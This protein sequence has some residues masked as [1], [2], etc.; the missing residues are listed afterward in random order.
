MISWI[1]LYHWEDLLFA[2]FVGTVPAEIEDDTQV[3]EVRSSTGETV[4]LPCVVTG[5][6]Q[7][8]IH[9]TH[10]GNDVIT[11]RF[12]LIET[13]LEIT[14]VQPDDKGEYICEAWN[15]YGTSR[16]KQ[17]ILTVEG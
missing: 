3:V 6:P 15:G 2:G 5:T 13:G 17:I 1:S 14:D 10:D 11:Q 8:T 7:P 12:Q 16:Q 9:W 4:R